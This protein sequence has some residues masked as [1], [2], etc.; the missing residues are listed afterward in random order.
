[1][2]SSLSNLVNNPSEGI[3]KVKCKYGHNSKIYETCGITY[4]LCSMII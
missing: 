1:M 3:D 2:A 4:E